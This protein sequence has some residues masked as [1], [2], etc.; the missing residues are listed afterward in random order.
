MFNIRLS[1]KKRV[2][3][4]LKE[5]ENFM[6]T[7]FI[8]LSVSFHFTTAKADVEKVEYN[9]LPRYRNVQLDVTIFKGKEYNSENAAL[10]FIVDH[11]YTNT[12]ECTFQLELQTT[13]GDLVKQ[14]FANIPVYAARTSQKNFMAQVSQ[15]E[16]PIISALNLTNTKRF[17]KKA[18]C[19]GRDERKPL[20]A[21]FCAN[22]SETKVCELM[23]PGQK[24]YP[25]M[26]ENFFLGNCR[27]D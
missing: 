8:L 14:I 13:G 10:F 17:T 11:P 27:C 4:A 15:T 5:M 26:W 23:Y 6:K 20:P 1:T 18:T 3:L 19:H 22:A 7:L 12:L 16:Y 21:Q 2:Q 9:D 24:I 25:V